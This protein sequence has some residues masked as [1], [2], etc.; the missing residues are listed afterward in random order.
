MK[1]VLNQAE[2]TRNKMLPVTKLETGTIQSKGKLH[3]IFYVV[4]TMYF[5]SSREKPPEESDVH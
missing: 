4:F 3:V 1:G 2:I 5:N